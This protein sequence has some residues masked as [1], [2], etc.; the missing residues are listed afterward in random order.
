[1]S[2][3]FNFDQPPPLYAVMGNPVAHSRSPEIHQLFAQQ[4][5]IS[6]QYQRIQV[7]VG[8]FAQAVS[9]FQA[10]G[11][12]GLNITLPF[13]VEAWELCDVVSENAQS[14]GAVNTIWFDDTAIH[15]DNTDGKGIVTDIT[16]NLKCPIFNKAVLVLG[17]G[18]AVRGVLAELLT[19]RP[20]SVVIA[21]RTVDKAVEL[22]QQFRSKSQSELKG[23]GLAEVQGLAVDI[24][25]NG[26]SASLS[27]E[28]PPLPGFTVN[29]GALAYDMVYAEQPTA[30]MD[31]ASELGFNKSS[32]GLGMLVEQ[33]AES[34]YLWHH[35]RPRTQPV[36]QALRG[37]QSFQ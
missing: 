26:T 17:A 16:L 33:A 10:S 35:R 8:G 28:V 30:F 29:D 31:W 36:I 14:A 2:D 19:L 9:N 21:N 22:S 20:A 13:K 1:M 3:L 4:L 32:D 12:Q 7:D 27:G 6:I 11:G 23:C 18:G 25:I 24:V 15:G 5:A 34:F 37:G